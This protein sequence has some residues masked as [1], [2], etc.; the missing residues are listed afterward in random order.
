MPVPISCYRY[1]SS[2][3]CAN[4]Q[5]DSPSPHNSPCE[6]K[7]QN[8]RKN[9]KQPCTSSITVQLHLL[10][11]F[12]RFFSTIRFFSLFVSFKLITLNN[13]KENNEILTY[14]GLQTQKEEESCVKMA[15]NCSKLPINCMWSSAIPYPPH[16]PTEVGVYHSSRAAIIHS[17]FFS[18]CCS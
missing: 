14:L 18:F 8:L 13:N 6:S 7:N 9:Q 11:P 4:I 2:I 15:E 3:P 16:T 5:F 17:I 1:H 10:K 12:P